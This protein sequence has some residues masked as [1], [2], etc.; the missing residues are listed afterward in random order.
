MELNK[1]HVAATVE[2]REMIGDKINPPGVEVR[3]KK[4]ENSD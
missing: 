1:F 2:G 3:G 4:E